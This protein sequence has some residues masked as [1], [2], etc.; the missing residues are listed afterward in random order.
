MQLAH[1]YR[2]IDAAQVSVDLS[3]IGDIPNTESVVRPSSPFR[4]NSSAMDGRR[5]RRSNFV[6][7]VERGRAKNP[8]GKRRLFSPATMG[9]FYCL[10]IKKAGQERDKM[11]NG[12]KRKR[13]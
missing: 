10:K 1:A 9:G 6:Y 11:T 5:R 2:L 3:P 12:R 7:F 8:T 4:P 13:A